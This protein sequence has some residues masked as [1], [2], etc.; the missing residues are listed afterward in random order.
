MITVV[1]SAASTA[2]LYGTDFSSKPS[3]RGREICG[4]NH[5]FD[6]NMETNS[7]NALSY[8]KKF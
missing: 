5:I 1:I 6:E 7:I 4:G 2:T 8:I 3:R